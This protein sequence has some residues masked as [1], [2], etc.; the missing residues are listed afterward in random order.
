MELG[1]GVEMC[2]RMEL[3][4]GGETFS[5]YIHKPAMLMWQ[6]VST[7]GAKSIAPG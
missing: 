2:P 4:V 5:W 7:V 6:Y 3:S 1:S